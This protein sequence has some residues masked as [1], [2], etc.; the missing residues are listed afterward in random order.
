MKKLITGGIVTALIASNV[1][2]C[3]QW[4]EDNIKSDHKITSLTQNKNKLEQSLSDKDKLIN[5]YQKDIDTY[6][7]KVSK[8]NSENK[9]LNNQI[10]KL[11][12]DLKKEKGK[13]DCPSVSSKRVLKTMAMELSFYTDSPDETGNNHSITKSGYDLKN[14]MTYQ[15][16]KIIA[17]DQNVLPMYS[18]VEIDGIGR[19]IVLDTGSYIQSNRLDVL[20][21]SKQEAFKRGRYNET[22]KVLRLGKGA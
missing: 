9:K 4:K 6:E 19:A 11:K 12:H 14:G 1:V 8:L 5:Q 7:S 13:S 21:S 10:D 15:G 20:V 2:A 22:V 18:I 16:M 17:A 3:H